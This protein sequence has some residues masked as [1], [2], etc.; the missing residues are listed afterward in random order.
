[1]KKSLSYLFICFSI[2]IVIVIIGE[3]IA[4]KIE[5]NP[6]YKVQSV[7][8]INLKKDFNQNEW[9]LNNIKNCS[10]EYFET[11][12]NYRK[13]LV[14]LDHLMD[15]ENKSLAVF[16]DDLGLTLTGRGPRKNLDKNIFVLGGSTIYG[17]GLECDEYTLPSNLNYAF[18]NKISFHNH[19]TS[20]YSSKESS[21]YFLKL[22]KHDKQ[23]EEVWFIEGINDVMRKVITGVPSYTYP[24]SALGMSS[25]LS[26]RYF[27]VESL[28]SRSALFR[29]IFQINPKL[30]G[31]IVESEKLYPKSIN[32]FK[33]ISNR[34]F[35][36]YRAKL[37]AE[38]T[39][40]NYL[41]VKDIANIK[42]I[43]LKIFSQPNLFDKKNLSNLEKKILDEINGYYPLDL[44]EF[45]FEKYYEN[46]NVISQKK[47][48]EI[49]DLRGCLN[50]Q[51]RSLF[52][53]PFHLAPHGNK[54]LAEC[55]VKKITY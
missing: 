22:I 31:N 52:F 2:S 3:I 50:K 45:A 35:I 39:I 29:I 32:N 17:D 6:Y 18:K 13:P 24:F 34:E 7:A 48:I 38:M 42:G 5:K 23:P 26:L 44:L 36:N 46:L 8:F 15:K 40:N 14:P 25:R 37:A 21:D 20:A 19:G 55:I 51:K 33:Q 30:N 53:D 54:L 10:L 16:T 4:K 27:I 11:F 49:I 28:A 1:M 9:K 43:K 12:N 41:F 47:K